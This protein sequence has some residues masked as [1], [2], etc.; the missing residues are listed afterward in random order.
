MEEANFKRNDDS[1]VYTGVSF[2]N[3]LS[4]MTKDKKSLAHE[5]H[6]KKNRKKKTP[7]KNN[8]PKV[9]KQQ[10]DLNWKMEIKLK[11]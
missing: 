4:R 10:Y 6:K 11:N 3:H 7:N 1:S 2:C 5:R 8:K 9:R